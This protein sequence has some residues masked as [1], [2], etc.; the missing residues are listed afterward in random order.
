M[1]LLWLMDVLLT[2]VT[3]TPRQPRATRAWETMWLVP[4]ICGSPTATTSS[5]VSTWLA[6]GACPVSDEVAHAGVNNDLAKCLHVRAPTM[7]LCSLVAFMHRD[8][9]VC[10]CRMAK[11]LWHAAST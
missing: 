10:S 2:S 11:Q 5:K 8:A 7:R 6:A 1:L 4:G 9:R 3:D